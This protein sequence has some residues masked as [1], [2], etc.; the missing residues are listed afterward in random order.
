MARR[1]GS[2]SSSGAVRLAAGMPVV[3]LY[4]KDDFLRQQYTSQLKHELD[5]VHGS[6]GVQ[7]VRF[8]GATAQVADILDECRSM[9]LMTAHKLVIVDS[10]DELL[11]SSSDDDDG[12]G[13]GDG[14][15][16]G[17]GKAS[18]KRAAGKGKGGGGGVR[19]F[20]PKSAR[21][22]VEAYVNEPSSAATLVLRAATWR[23]GNLDKAVKSAGGEMIKCEP[24]DAHTAARWAI[25]RC[26]KRHRAQINPQAAAL[27]IEHVGTALARIDSELAK[28]AAAVDDTA[29]G[30]PGAGEAGGAEAQATARITADD[31]R[32]M[33]G[34]S[35]EEDFWS[36]Q[37]SLL[38]GDAKRALEHLGELLDVSRHDPVPIFFS[39]LDLARKLHVASCAIDAGAGPREAAKAAGLWGPAAEVVPH[40]ARS[41]GQA[42]CATLLHEAVELDSMSKSG[43]TE[44]RM[45]LERLVLRFASVRG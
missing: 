28:L 9:G 36:I 39:C 17:S 38:D 24:L 44:P 16:G 30:T 35:R 11:K 7:V 21:E 8:D 15:G 41:L 34:L 19:R 10:A 32:A 3:I 13:N 29:T 4:G 1:S 12:D 6:D 42:R 20:A 25:A 31:V 14:G 22:L 33:V 18:G 45:A 40:M 43:R 27:L 37:R 26:A 5:E 23:P 2:S